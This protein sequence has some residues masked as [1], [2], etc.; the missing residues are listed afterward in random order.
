MTTTTTIRQE[1]LVPNPRDVES[2]LPIINYTPN[3]HQI[4]YISVGIS[5]FSSS[6][7]GFIREIT[8]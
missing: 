5:H 1:L 4:G 3:H 8:F 2:L 7:P 6:A